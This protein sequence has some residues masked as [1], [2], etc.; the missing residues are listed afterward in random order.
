MSAI[1]IANRYAKSLIDLAQETGKLERI[2]EDINSFEGVLESR[3]FYLMLKSPIIKSDKKGQIFKA[4]FEGKFDEMTMA[5][6]EIL[7]RKGRESILPEIAKEFLTQYKIIKHISNVKLITATELGKDTVEA[8]RKELVASVSTDD[9]VV[10]E[11]EVDPELIGGFVLEY[12][13][14]L[15]DASV[16][17]KL[18][19][20]SKNFKDNLYIS[21]IIAD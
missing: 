14:K 15:Y 21:Q 7:L 12:D 5:F 1:R 19:L 17:H 10:I 16:K 8:I 9:N 13:D 2:L 18:D 4:L 3:D 20:L 6:L 11:T